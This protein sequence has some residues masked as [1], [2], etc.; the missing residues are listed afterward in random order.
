MDI[1]KFNKELSYKVAKANGLEKIHKYQ[2]AV[3]LWLE[4]S[5]MTLRVSKTPNL[6]FSYKSMLID[7]T[8]QMI[9]HI[10]NLKQKLI[11][12]RRV[13]QH[14]EQKPIYQNMVSEIETKPTISE[15]KV[16]SVPNSIS[17]NSI[18]SETIITQDDSNEVKVV[19]NSDI[20][21]L[22][23][24]FKEIETTEE[25]KI[26]TPH[27][28]EYVKKLISQDHNM[29]IFKQEEKDLLLQKRIEPDSPSDKSN[30]ICFACGSEISFKS[31]K[32][33]TCGTDLK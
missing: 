5:E 14:I 21:N 6:E 19:K 31:R 26:I 25:F 23:I 15:T 11:S 4:I 29:D 32:C 16:K 3:D 2:E 30:I 10:K 7:K 8:K 13:A 27:D 20:K 9:E 18:E 1:A 17:E 28:E 33:P 22:P 24:G 12:Q